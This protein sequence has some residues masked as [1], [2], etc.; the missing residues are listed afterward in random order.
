MPKPASLWWTSTYEAP[1]IQRQSC[2]GGLWEPGSGA[3]A[4]SALVP[5]DDVNGVLVWHP[6]S[7]DR[8]GDGAVGAVLG[9]VRRCCEGGTTA[10]LG[11]TERC[12]GAYREVV[13]GR[14]GGGGGEERR[15]GGRLEGREG[16][17]KGGARKGA[18]FFSPLPS[19]TK[20]RALSWTSSFVTA[21]FNFRTTSRLLKIQCNGVPKLKS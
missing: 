4:E 2:S 3:L 16:L 10:V 1:G 8:T 20:V 14:E 15:V 5:Q 18:L 7:G 12:C 13:L 11:A 17:G 19:Q 6:W 9:T 21:I